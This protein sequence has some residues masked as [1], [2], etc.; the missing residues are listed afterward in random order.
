MSELNI[1]D[2]GLNI[3]VNVC[4][5]KRDK[6]TGRILQQVKEHNRCLNTQLLGLV[7]FLNGDYNHTAPKMEQDY[8]N[9]IPRYLGVGTNTAAAPNL[10]VGTTVDVNDTRLLNEISPRMLLPESRQIIKKPGQ[11]Y[12]QLVIESYLPSKYYNN[13]TINEAGLFAKEEGNNCLF[14]IVFSPG[15]TKTEDS[16]VQI[17]WTIT[18]ISIDSENKPTVIIDKDPLEKAFINALDTIGEKYPNCKELCDAIY[19]ATETENTGIYI[20]ADR[21][22]SQDSI[23]TIST[24]INTLTAK[25]KTEPDAEDIPT[26][27]QISEEILGENSEESNT[28]NES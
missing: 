27:I 11:D 22:T 6:K 12:I 1:K 9:W 19:S 14:R 2:A 17:S 18:I 23:D 4:I 16:V 24:K 10:P 28:N 5:T 20:Y 25:L 21:A 8:F 15:V 7:K 26:C 13:T 3:G